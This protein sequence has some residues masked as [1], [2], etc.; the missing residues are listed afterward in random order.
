M[1]QNK[2]FNHHKYKWTHPFGWVRHSWEFVGPDGGVSFNV[3][4]A[5]D[6]KYGNTCGL[7][8]HFCARSGVTSGAPDYT[9]CHLTG[10]PCWHEGTSLYAEESL[11]PVVEPALKSGEH[12]FIFCTLER[13]Y[14]R[15]FERAA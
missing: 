13:E 2:K 5:D 3:S 1:R 11:W 4:V 6:E 8:F 10:E 7:E 12:D 9:T 15:V 14:E